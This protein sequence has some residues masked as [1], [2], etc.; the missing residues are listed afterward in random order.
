M[1]PANLKFC[2][3]HQAKAPQKRVQRRGQEIFS[4]RSKLNPW[5][6]VKSFLNFEDI[7]PHGIISNKTGFGIQSNWLRRLRALTAIEIKKTNEM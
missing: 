2:P 6:K 7:K 5:W 1:R 3:L 4:C